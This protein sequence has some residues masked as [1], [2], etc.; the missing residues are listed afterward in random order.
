MKF[1]FNLN[2]VDYHHGITKDGQS[3]GVSE[4]VLSSRRWASL[5]VERLALA[6]LQCAAKPT[7]ISS[8]ISHYIRVNGKKSYEE[9]AGH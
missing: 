2:E 6:N 5:N 9:R 8:S 3:I 1:L 7:R 4:L